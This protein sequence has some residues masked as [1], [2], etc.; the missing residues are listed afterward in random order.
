MIGVS[1]TARGFYSVCAVA[2]ISA[3]SF[4]GCASYTD[5]TRAIRSEF[6]QG[7]YTTALGSIDQSSLKTSSSS[8]LLYHLERSMILDR[9]GD[10]DKSR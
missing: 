10:A 6:V 1:A 2:A 5:E 7:D 8:R 4:S 3:V 9:M